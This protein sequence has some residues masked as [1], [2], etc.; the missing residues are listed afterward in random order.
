MPRDDLLTHNQ[1]RQLHCEL[2]AGNEQPAGFPKWLLDMVNIAD[3]GCGTSLACHEGIMMNVYKCD[4]AIDG[5]AGT[6]TIKQKGEMKNP[7]ESNKGIGYT[8]GCVS[9][10]SVSRPQP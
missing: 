3:S 5:A 4:T 6:F 1:A 7:I 8:P 10:C 9:R 2:L